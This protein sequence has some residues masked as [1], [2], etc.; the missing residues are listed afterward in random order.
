M[1]SEEGLI[2]LSGDGT[3][4]WTNPAA[5]DLLGYARSEL[6]Q[7]ALPLLGGNTM[8]P[9]GDAF[10]AILKGEAAEREGDARFP[11]REGKR[12]AVHWKLW[13]LSI[14]PGYEQC[15]LTISQ[16][17]QASAEG[18]IT[19]G[20]RDVFEHAVE[21][22]FRSTFDGHLIEVNPAFARMYGYA[23]A[24]E[25]MDKMRDL[26]TQLYVHPERRTEFL[27]CMRELGFVA[28][29][30]SEAWRADGSIL[31]IAEFARTVRGKDQEPLYFEGSVI[32]I[33]ERKLAESALKRSEETFRRLAETTHVVPFEFYL[34]AQMF[35]YLGPQAEALF[36]HSLAHGCALE[37]WE[38]IVHPDDLKL[39]TQFARGMGELSVQ[40]FET[41]FRV[42]AADGRIIWVKQIVH[43]AAE[44]DD[45]EQVRGFLF[46]ITKAKREE[47][48]R[49]QSRLQLRELAARSQEVREEERMSVAREI[50]DE[51]GQALTLMKIDLAWLGSRLARAVLEEVRK[52]LE[53]KLASMEDTI[54]KTLQA[55]RRILSALRPPLLDELGLK[56]AIEFQMQEFSKR[57][58]VRYELD[59]EPV[60]ALPA[61]DVSAVFRI[62]QESL[63]NVARHAKASRIKVHLRQSES[64][65]VMKVED[66][67]CGIS[68][69]RLRH[70]K[71]FG[72]LGMRERA[73]AIGA[74]LEMNAALG[75]G[76]TVTLKVP[77]RIKNGKGPASAS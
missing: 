31:W 4:R 52:P 10:Q 1:R 3:I 33:T 16:T 53:E 59:V 27:R 66:N 7:M 50:H 54:N 74:E 73:W 24:A 37:D 48:D 42:R 5:A 13:G 43:R 56:D 70:S 39:G 69:D 29:F 38:T 26:N 58:G 17:A 40:D 46:D 64:Q 75:A 49:E 9:V 60:S 32:D 76:T 36:G 21:G 51:L 68:E 22:L 71:N 72:L 23:T 19:A 45:R 62:F 47:E 65:V 30:E 34:P 25:A 28:N 67:G 20:Y 41:E 12:I 8:G 61:T 63:T 18:V 15:L 57:V 77:I 2:L 6:V 35:I 55:V 44:G 14:V 11:D